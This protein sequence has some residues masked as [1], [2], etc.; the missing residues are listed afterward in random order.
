[1]HLS[2]AK[3]GETPSLEDLESMLKQI[4]QRIESIQSRKKQG[5]LKQ[6]SSATKNKP[7]KGV[8]SDYDSMMHQIKDLLHL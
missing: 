8:H 2:L 3:I 7:K 1:M 5:V 4:D 6:A